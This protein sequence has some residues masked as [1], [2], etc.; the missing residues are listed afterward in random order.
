MPEKRIT[1]SYNSES[2]EGRQVE[3]RLKANAGNVSAYIRRRIIDDPLPEDELEY[4]RKENR[5]LKDKFEALSRKVDELSKGGVVR[6]SE[7]LEA[8]EDGEVKSGWVK[9]F[10]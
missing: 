9:R 6:Q 1:F 4:L 7:E 3:R 10:R 2:E 8:V 5:D